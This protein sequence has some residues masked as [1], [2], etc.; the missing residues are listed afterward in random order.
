[1]ALLYV[2]DRGASFRLPARVRVQGHFRRDPRNCELP[3]IKIRLK[4][5][6]REGTPFA[7]H[8]TLKLVTACQDE[9]YVLR[10]YLV[11]RAYQCLTPESF[12]VRLAK[13]TFEGTQGDQAPFTQYAFFIEDDRTLAHRLG[14]KR[15]P[16]E[17]HIRPDSIATEQCLLMRMFQYMVGN[18]DWDIYLRKNLELIHLPAENRIIAVPYDFDWCKAVDPPYT[19]LGDSFQW[20]VFRKPCPSPA[21]LQAVIDRFEIAQEPIRKLYKRFPHAGGSWTREPIQYIDDFYQM[22][23]QAEEVQ[24]VFLAD[25][26]ADGPAGDR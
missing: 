2:K 3:P 25:C 7:A 20:R 23:G 11:Y 10:E 14:G 1:M 19:H 24:Q 16:D 22:L 9:E 6:D 13:V 17:V 15:L 26:P 21:T 4:R 5:E 8:K 12:R 18:T